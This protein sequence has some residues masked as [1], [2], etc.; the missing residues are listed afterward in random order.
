MIYLLILKFIAMTREELLKLKEDLQKE[1]GSIDEELSGIA[2]ENPAVRGDFDVKVEDIGSSLE[3][4]AQ[5]AGEL[6]RL[7]ALVDALERRRKEIVNILE[8]IEQGTYGK[9]QDCLAEINPDRLKA[10]PV[11]SLCIS[12]AGKKNF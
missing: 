2:T 6:E 7:Q 5:E 9:C 1:L 11:A 8:K 12:C 3:D 4:A 10:M